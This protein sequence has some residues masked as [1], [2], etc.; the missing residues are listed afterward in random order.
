MNIIDIITLK[1]PGIEGITY[2]NTQ[3]DGTAW[4]DPYEGLV[5]ENKDIPKPT[6][7]E[8]AKW[9]LEV[10]AE[11]DKNQILLKRQQAYPPKEDL[12]IALWEKIFENKPELAD[13]LQAK[14]EEIKASYPLPTNTTTTIK[15]K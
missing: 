5:W 1:Y 10:T 2:W 13:Q 9:E 11:Y 14:R 6:K 3:Y 15:A 12:I 8:L 4:E 7:K